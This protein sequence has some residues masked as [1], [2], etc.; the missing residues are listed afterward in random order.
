MWAKIPFY[1]CGC[2]QVVDSTSFPAQGKELWATLY[3][4][5]RMGLNFPTQAMR[6]LN[7][8]TSKGSASSQ[9]PE[10][11]NSDVYFGS[12]CLLPKISCRT[13]GREAWSV[14]FL[15]CVERDQERLVHLFPFWEFYQLP[16]GD[17]CKRA[18]SQ[19]GWQLRLLVATS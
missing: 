14:H 2:C 11:S 3:W 4:L 12:L 19:C 16:Q 17:L 15:M 7:Q 18:P 8:M 1:F 13:D 9:I 6:G 5:S 10:L